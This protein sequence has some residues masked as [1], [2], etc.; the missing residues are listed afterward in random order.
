[1]P[2]WWDA[3]RGEVGMNIGHLSRVTF[4]ENL[5]QLRVG[6]RAPLAALCI[7]AAI[8][9]TGGATSL[10]Q[11]V[12]Q[13]IFNQSLVPP[14][15][16][17][18]AL[19][20]DTVKFKVRF[21]NAGATIGF[22]PFI[23]LALNFR[24][25]DNNFPGPPSPGPCDGLNFISAQMVDVNGPPIPLA[26]TTTR[27]GNVNPINCSVPQNPM[28]PYA[29]VGLITLSQGWQLVTI[30]LPFGSFDQSQPEIVVEVTAQVH[31]FA[32]AGIP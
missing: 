1:M 2:E 30:G 17:S 28:H 10:A 5:G 13:T 25:N 26:S 4:S 21:K 3:S 9:F 20:G 12:P 15:V 18:N 19:I 8:A 11:P 16:P 32:D 29:G 31:N 6:R 24:G 27:Y 22:G 23:D 7:A 14:D